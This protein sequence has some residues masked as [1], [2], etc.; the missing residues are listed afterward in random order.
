[1][2]SA[3]F[4]PALLLI[5]VTAAPAR[6]IQHERLESSNI[7][8]QTPASTGLLLISVKCP[9]SDRPDA[10]AESHSALVPAP[11]YLGQRNSDNATRSG[12]FVQDF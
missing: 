4:H 6:F 10:Q 7:T 2:G 11:V 5:G 12:D 8:L 9:S 3:T 1:M